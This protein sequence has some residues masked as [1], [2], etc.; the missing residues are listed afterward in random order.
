MWIFIH[1]NVAELTDW[2]MHHSQNRKK[3]SSTEQQVEEIWHKIMP[4]NVLREQPM[5]SPNVHVYMHVH[6][7]QNMEGTLW[8][9]VW[10]NKLGVKQHKKATKTLSRV[11]SI[12]MYSVIPTVAAVRFF[13]LLSW[14]LIITVLCCNFNAYSS[15]WNGFLLFNCDVV[16]LKGKE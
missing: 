1:L 6:I 12:S 14:T 3:R 7:L 5:N 15:S 11:S 2:N 16:I 4:Q 10:S 13:P 8:H 9:N